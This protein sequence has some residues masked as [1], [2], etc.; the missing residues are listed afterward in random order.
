MLRFSRT[1]VVFLAIFL[2]TGTCFAQSFRIDSKD[3]Q[4]INPDDSFSSI[5]GRFAVAL[6]KQISGY[7]PN[8]TNTPNGRVETINFGWRTAAGVFLIGYT[9]KPET[10]EGQSTRELNSLRDN[11]VNGLLDG[12][13]LTSES[14]LSL[15]GHPGR[16]LNFELTDGLMTLRL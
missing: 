10:L 11:I 3:P 13:K 2:L 1:A 4:Q 16:Q 14:D 8:V 5:D 7:A 15:D 12:G 9:D 6:P